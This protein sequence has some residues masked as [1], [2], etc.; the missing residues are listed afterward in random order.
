[1]D[2]SSKI[3]SVNLSE[4]ILPTDLIKKI[5]TALM[6]EYQFI[7][8]N[9]KDDILTCVFGEPPHAETV[10]AIGLITD[11]KIKA[12]LG[13]KDDIQ[14]RLNELFP[15]SIHRTKAKP[16]SKPALYRYPGRIPSPV[17]RYFTRSSDAFILKSPLALSRLTIY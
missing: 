2:D 10:T 13:P 8:I 12:V 11:Y 1:M 4:L 15:E 5:S 3:E 14:R 9:L 6:K 17:P 16:A 7:P